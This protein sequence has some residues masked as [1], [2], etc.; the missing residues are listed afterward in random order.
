MSM[1]N[2]DYRFESPSYSKR[3]IAGISVAQLC[4]LVDVHRNTV[5]YW[6]KTEKLYNGK[7]PVKQVKSMYRLLVEKEVIDAEA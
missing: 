2:G 6:L 5:Y 4:Q 7:D 3:F 1:Y